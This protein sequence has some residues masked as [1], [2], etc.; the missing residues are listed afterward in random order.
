MNISCYSRGRAGKH[1]RAHAHTRT[2]THTRTHARIHSPPLKPPAFFATV[3]LALQTPRSD[4]GFD[5]RLSPYVITLLS[6]MTQYPVSLY[7]YPVHKKA[8][9]PLKIYTLTRYFIDDLLSGI[10]IIF[11]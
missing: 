1:T 4:R 3:Q 6:P 10:A 9:K 2:H 8:Q 7:H 11:L 5:S